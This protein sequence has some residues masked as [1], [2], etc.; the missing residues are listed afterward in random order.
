MARDMNLK[1]RL[2]AFIAL[3][4]VRLVSE[5]VLLQSLSKKILG[6][7]SEGSSLT[8]CIVKESKCPMSC[9]A[10]AF[11]H[12]IEDEFHEVP[13]ILSPVASFCWKSSLPGVLYLVFMNFR[14]LIKN[15]CS[16]NFMFLCSR[17]EQLLVNPWGCSQGFL[18]S[19]LKMPWTY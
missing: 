9:A 5:G 13:T 8:E 4:G 2:E 15:S 17:Y 1:V 6:S 16:S 19:L 18:S 3:G 7:K 10:G 14:P 12:G 11:V